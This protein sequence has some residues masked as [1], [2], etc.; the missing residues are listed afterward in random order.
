[1]S[2]CK[3][4]CKCKYDGCTS[5]PVFNV[6]GETKGRFCSQHKEVGMVDVKNKRCEYDGCT[7]R[8]VFNVSGETKGRFCSGHKEVGMVDVKNKR[9]EHDGCTSRPSYGYPGQPSSFCAIHKVDSTMLHS[10]KRCTVQNCKNWSTHGL[11]KPQRCETHAIIDDKNLVERACQ[12]CN[13]VDIVNRDGVCESC[14]HWFRKRPRLAKQ[15]EVFQFLESQ[16]PDKPCTSIDKIPTGLKDCGDKERPDGLW[17]LA[18]RNVLLEVDEDQHDTRPCHCE[19]TRMMN[20]SQ[21]LGCERTIWIRYNPDSFKSL[22]SRKWSSAHKRLHLLKMWLEWAFTVDLT[23]L[24]TISVV[25]L[26]FDNFTEGKVK[27]ETLL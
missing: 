6:S 21:A 2:N 4:S 27:V 16:M 24:S 14:D 9:C 15:R 7:S 3:R 11:V 13:L 20:I 5:Y 18:D 10:K 1:M 8:P 22:E 23:T 19:Q 17:E 12:N 25:Y 26:F